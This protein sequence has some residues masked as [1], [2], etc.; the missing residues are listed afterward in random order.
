MWYAAGIDTL[1]F[2]I[3]A[4]AGIRII[5]FDASRCVDS[6]THQGR[7]C[8]FDTIGK[9]RRWGGETAKMSKYLLT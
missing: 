1:H 3:P 7:S 9:A 5:P 6:D 4:R 2:V 8:H